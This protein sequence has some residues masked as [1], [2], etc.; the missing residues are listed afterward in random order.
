MTAVRCRQ[1][2]FIPALDTLPDPDEDPA[3]EARL[4]SVAMTR[5]TEHPVMAS[6]GDSAFVDR[7]ASASSSTVDDMEG[8]CPLRSFRLQG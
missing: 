1:R 2:V 3:A 5:A 4:L 6:A 8:P 7:V